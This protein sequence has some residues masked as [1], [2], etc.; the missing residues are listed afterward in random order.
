MIPL[1]FVI[2]DSLVVRKT[3]E[4]SL[5]QATVEVI[6]F[7]DGVEAL[8]WMTA[9]EARI[10]N[11]VFVDIGMPK[12]DGYEVIRRLKSKPAFAG[13][14]FVMLTRRDGMIDSLKSRLVGATVHMTKPFKTQDILKV[15][16][17]QLH[18]P[19]HS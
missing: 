2:D 19:V 16:S 1:I 3:L 7:N 6:S 11:L 13:T 5:R 12:M 18:I 9:P 8:R 4:L 17:E 15:V 14:I 10:P